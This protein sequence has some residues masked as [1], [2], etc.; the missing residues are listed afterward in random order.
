MVDAQIALA[1]RGIRERWRPFLR[2]KEKMGEVD[3]ELQQRARDAQPNQAAHLE[4]LFQKSVW[5][6]GRRPDCSDCVR[7]A[8]YYEKANNFEAAARA[9]R[10]MLFW[11]SVDSV[12]DPP[13]IQRFI[14]DDGIHGARFVTL[15]GTEGAYHSLQRSCRWN[16]LLN[17]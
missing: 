15:Y 9:H 5:E 12:F 2:P 7:L 16:L 14:D 11:W 3:F 17:V 13:R 6:A 10:E 4:E 1:K 8:L